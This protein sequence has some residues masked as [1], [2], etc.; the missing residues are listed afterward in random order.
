[1]WWLNFIPDSWIQIFVHGV[2]SIGAILL[3]LGIFDK[4]IPFVSRYSIILKILGFVIFT[5]GIFFEGG[6]G[7]EMSWRARASDLQSKIVTAQQQ[8]VAANAKLNA[9][10]NNKKVIVQQKVKYVESQIE[11]N[12]SAI[13]SDCKLDDTAW[14]LYNRAVQPPQVSASSPAASSSSPKSNSSSSR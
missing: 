5:V 9:A 8:S 12:R 10:L 11:Q 1:M 4:Y 13:N 7:V 2:V 3:L 14:M 6:Y